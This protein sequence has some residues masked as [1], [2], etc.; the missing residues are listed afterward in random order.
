VRV[1]GFTLGVGSGA[2]VTV[3]AIFSFVLCG[4]LCP[5]AI[6]VAA[7][8]AWKAV[9]RSVTADI[10]WGVAVGVLCAIVGALLELHS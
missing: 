2:L 1:L 9:G 3:L 8:I 7:W 5:A 10:A 4:P 6:A